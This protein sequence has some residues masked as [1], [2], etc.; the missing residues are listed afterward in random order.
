MLHD[1]TTIN[2]QHHSTL[3]VSHILI[4]NT[5]FIAPNNG[6]HGGGARFLSET[7]PV[8]PDLALEASFSATKI[9]F[10][11]VRSVRA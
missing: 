8:G 2:Q 11:N 10:L 5:L 1:V 4:R 3:A 7:S 9:S 6:Q